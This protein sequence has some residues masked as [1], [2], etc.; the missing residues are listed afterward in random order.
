MRIKSFIPILVLLLFCLGAFTQGFYSYRIPMLNGDTLECSALRGQKTMLVS[1]IP[2]KPDSA[3]NAIL[4]FA[5]ANP[6]L[7][8][9]G[10]LSGEGS[11][12][13]GAGDML[14]LYGGTPIKLASPGYL[15]KTA[16]AQQFGI[17]QWLT[18]K[19]L[20]LHFDREAEPGTR[21]FVDETGRLYAVIGAQTPWDSPIF[22]KILNA[23]PP[24][25]PQ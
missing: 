5:N 24:L 12:M 6:G 10:L 11:S 17:A 18:R 25:S 3:F 16:G 23:K 21:F 19:E 15:G 20:N 14:R 2:Q 9:I 22:E 8:V 7:I 1:G 13:T 4:S